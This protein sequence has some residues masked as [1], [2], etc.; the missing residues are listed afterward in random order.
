MDEIGEVVRDV[1]FSK[2]PRCLGEFMKNVDEA[3]V[4]LEARYCW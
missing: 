4:V 2:D 3:T 1:K